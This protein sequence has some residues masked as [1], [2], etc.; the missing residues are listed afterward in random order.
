M[1]EASTQTYTVRTVKG[2]TYPSRVRAGNTF[3]RGEDNVVELTNDQAALIRDDSQLEITKGAPEPQEPTDD[4]TDQ[5]ETNP[6]GNHINVVAGDNSGDTVP[7]NPDAEDTTTA[8]SEAGNESAPA[9]EAGAESDEAPSV[10]TLVRDN[11]RADLDAQA[12][13]AGVENPSELASKTEVAE[14]IVAKR[15]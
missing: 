10:E 13:E 3:V 2:F 5:A 4:S 9:D 1:A 11:S 14:A 15:G 6:S 12:T 7:A 8:P